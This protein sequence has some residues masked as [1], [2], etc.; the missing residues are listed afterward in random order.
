MRPEY[1]GVPCV[2]HGC[3]KCCTEAEMPLTEADVGR[4]EALG[5]RRERF[6]VL[7]DEWV[8]QLRMVD[9]H[10]FFLGPTGRCS[11]H[12]ARPIGC[13]LY[14]MVWDQ[15]TGRVARD[16]FCPFVREFPTDPDVDRQVAEVLATL[17][18]EAEVR[19][20]AGPAKP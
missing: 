9:G 13:R 18:R 4:L 8:P 17:R 6:S 7:D 5:H 19:R 15:Y 11:V 16:D 20:V 12:D 14:P 10:C 3:H 1:D 2:R